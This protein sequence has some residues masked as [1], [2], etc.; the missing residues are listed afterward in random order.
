[1]RNNISEQSAERFARI[2]DKITDRRASEVSRSDVEFLIGMVEDNA[3]DA[4]RLDT[5]LGEAQAK[6]REFERLDAAKA[7]RACMVCGGT[8]DGERHPTEG[9]LTCDECHGSGKVRA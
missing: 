8:G 6:I 2:K 7:E 3:A 9:T 1:V 5:E 4:N